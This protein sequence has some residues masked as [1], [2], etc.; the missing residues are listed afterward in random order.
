MRHWRIV[1]LPSRPRGLRGEFLGF[2]PY[3]NM[4]ANRHATRPNSEALEVPALRLAPIL[5]LPAIR[6]RLDTRLPSS[7]KSL[8][9][10]R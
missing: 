5:L 3:F 10:G 7:S 8:A 1:G 2:S 9:A 4:P 6:R